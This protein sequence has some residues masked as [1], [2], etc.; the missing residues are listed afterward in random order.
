MVNYAYPELPYDPIV[1][2]RVG[3]DAE[4]TEIA[5]KYLEDTEDDS[6]QAQIRSLGLSRQSNMTA[7]MNLMKD[8][9]K[10]RVLHNT[11]GHVKNLYKAQK[12]DDVEKSAESARKLEKRL[13]PPPDREGDQEL[14]MTFSIAKLVVN[15]VR[16]RQQNY[17][18]EFRILGR[19][20]PH[21]EAVTSLVL[22]A[23]KDQL[24][25]SHRG[26]FV[27][28]L[29]SCLIRKKNTE[30]RQE[31]D[32][33]S[34]S[35]VQPAHKKRRNN[36]SGLR[37]QE[38][39]ARSEPHSPAR[40]LQG[41]SRKDRRNKVL[42]ED[43]EDEPAA[44]STGL[45]AIRTRK[46]RKVVSC[47]TCQKKIPSIPPRQFPQCVACRKRAQEQ[48]SVHQQAPAPTAVMVA[49]T[50]VMVPPRF[51][52]TAVMVASTPL[53]EQPFQLQSSWV[54]GDSSEIEIL[55]QR[56]R[57]QEIEKDGLKAI[58]R[59]QNGEYALQKVELESLRT[60][61]MQL[62]RRVQQLEERT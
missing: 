4:L 37:A 39:G 5:C 47:T 32:D 30:K 35:D 21:F 45:S 11:L 19:E 58:V 10:A 14:A 15:V 3:E 43:E 7:A 16:S 29:L 6:L 24:D 26:F 59:E 1:A 46:T 44:S 50:A 22:E 33:E 42:L 57:M 20:V 62:K 53:G 2:K 38:S 61:N 60:E 17:S 56:I 34:A 52:S 18:N 41:S 9:N 28:G 13:Q 55:E 51:A 12:E 49:P 25:R 27:R 40:V 8:I 31:T 48:P 23:L 54:H 36:V